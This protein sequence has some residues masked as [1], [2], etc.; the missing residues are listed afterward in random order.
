[1]YDMHMHS[2]FSPDSKSTI[3]EL[4][5]MAIQNGFS[6]IAVTD[7]VH[8]AFFE[9]FNIL[10]NIQNCIRAISEAKENYRGKL[11]VFY[12]VEIGEYLDAPEKAKQILS[13]TEFDVVIGSLHY[14][15][16]NKWGAYTQG[17]PYDTATEAELVDFL[18]LYYHEMSA[19]IDAFSF[20]ILAHMLYPMRYINRDHGLGM[21]VFVCEKELKE[22]LKKIID[23][24]IALEMNQSGLLTPEGKF[25][26]DYDRLLEVYKEL[27]GNLIT[28]GSDAHKPEFQGKNFDLIMKNLQEKGFSEYYYFKNRKPHK[29]KI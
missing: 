18:K 1:M 6:G 9:K 14:V 29:V 27:G 2:M 5:Q 16:K 8:S 7:H 12:G 10:E 25:L 11:E 22:I 19:M 15:S 28:Y 20:D 17:I 13:L 3:D 26:P 4:C 23:K 24:N 21:D